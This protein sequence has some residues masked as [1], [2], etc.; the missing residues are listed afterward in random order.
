MDKKI[1]VGELVA[2]QM[3]SNTPRKLAPGYK[4]PKVQRMQS[5]PVGSKVKFEGR[6]YRVVER[7]KG[8]CYIVDS[9]HYTAYKRGTVSFE[10]LR[11]VYGSAFAV[12]SRKLTFAKEIFFRQD[13][14]C[15][16]AL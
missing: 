2:E 16:Q 15:L 4:N 8:V 7:K 12:E 1:V 10:T 9:D 5:F 11:N 14:Q 6:V 13:N 3:T